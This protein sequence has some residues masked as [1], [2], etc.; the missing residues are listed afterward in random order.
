MNFLL[1]IGYG[2]A[3]SSF[4]QRWFLNHPELFAGSGWDL[5]R[6]TY[7]EME[8]NQMNNKK[9]FV[10]SSEGL[11]SWL[12]HTEIG[13]QFDL[14]FDV[15]K[16]QLKICETL[17]YCFKESKILI[18]TRNLDDMVRSG[19]SQFVKTGGTLEWVDFIKIYSDLLLEIWDYNYLIKQYSKA[20][21]AENILVM[22]Y[23]L[24]RDDSEKFFLYLDDQLGLNYFRI[25]NEKVNP[26]LSKEELYFFP[27]ISRIVAILCN[28]LPFYNYTR[29]FRKH[30][31][32][33]RSG[34]YKLIVKLMKLLSFKKI[35]KDFFYS[36]KFFNVFKKNSNILNNYT[37]YNNYKNHYHLID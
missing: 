35:N 10:I 2:K 22:P 21:G 23:E 30:I 6:K 13:C 11:G 3:G 12:P 27:K 18:V 33:I 29:I 26:S 14:E 37:L 34:K 31:R 16:Y 17:K 24:L 7:S 8:K 15:K 20:F 25:P 1:H 5:C 9:Y 4:L 32:Y 36:E 19:Y 28:K